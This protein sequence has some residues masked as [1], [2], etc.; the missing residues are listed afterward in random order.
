MSS[1]M[2]VRQLHGLDLRRVLPKAFAKHH[3]Q[4]YTVSTSS[5]PISVK[6]PFQQ[7]QQ[8][9]KRGCLD[10]QKRI[11]ISCKCKR[12]DQF[13]QHSKYRHTQ[14]RH[15]HLCS[16]TRAM[17]GSAEYSLADQVQRFA[18]AKE[19]QNA[20]YLDIENSVYTEEAVSSLKGQSFRLMHPV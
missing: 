7:H 14:K 10:E 20:R 11:Q 19:A 5:V 12:R 9:S 4:A 15:R 3:H 8:S 6:L 1:C 13:R 18:N 2:K 16:N 17:S